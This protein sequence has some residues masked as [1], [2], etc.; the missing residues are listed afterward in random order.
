M[1]VTNTVQFYHYC[2]VALFEVSGTDFNRSPFL[3]DNSL[4]VLAILFFVVVVVV[5]VLLF[6]M[7]LII[8]FSNSM[9][10]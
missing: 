10:N 4:S 6:Q 3:V 9:K 5:F 2:S 7:N 8:A 1:P